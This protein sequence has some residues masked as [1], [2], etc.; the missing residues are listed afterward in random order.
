MKRASMFGSRKPSKTRYK[1]EPLEGIDKAP[2]EGQLVSRRKKHPSNKQKMAKLYY[3]LLFVLFLC[4]VAAL[5]YWGNEYMAS[6]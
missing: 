5:F 2:G 6:N 3:N 1:P 4:L